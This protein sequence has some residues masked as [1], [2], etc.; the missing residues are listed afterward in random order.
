[1]NG[2]S[3]RTKT[4]RVVGQGS[5]RIGVREGGSKSLKMGLRRTVFE[6]RPFFVFHKFSRPKGGAP[7][8]HRETKVYGNRYSKCLLSFAVVFDVLVPIKAEIFNS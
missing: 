2:G 4:F 5:Q 6:I 8:G 7:G 1:M 3:D